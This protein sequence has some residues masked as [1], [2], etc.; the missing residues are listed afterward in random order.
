MSGI[1]F[2]LDRQKSAL[3]GSDNSVVYFAKSLT[4]RDVISPML[5][6]I[7]DSLAFD[8]LREYVKLAFEELQQQI[9]AAF[10]S[11]LEASKL[12]IEIEFDLFD[13]WKIK[14]D[15]MSPSG[16]MTF[17]SLTKFDRYMVEEY[18]IQPLR[19]VSQADVQ[20]S[21]IPGL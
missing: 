13:G 2:Y 9:S 6:E 21:T 18:G 4:G 8:E 1:G 15:G 17:G 5:Q 14:I 11:G 20:Q 7:L 12:E 3:Q 19:P 16:R 10:N